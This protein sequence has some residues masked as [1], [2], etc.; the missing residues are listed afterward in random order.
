MNKIS[1]AI[2]DLINEVF[3]EVDYL[4]DDETA[5]IFLDSVRMT[6]LK[7][8]KS[9]FK[10][11]IRETLKYRLHFRIKENHIYSNRQLQLH[12]IDKLVDKT[13]ELLSLKIKNANNSV[14]EE[15]MEEF[16]YDC[17]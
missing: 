8:M 2:K 12:Y 7:E 5:F 3:S 13:L 14:E 10:Q 16:L 1:Q 9:D 6:A 4:S 15:G 17:Y 11:A